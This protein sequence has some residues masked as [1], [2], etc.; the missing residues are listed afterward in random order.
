MGYLRLTDFKYGDHVTFMAQ[1]WHSFVIDIHMFFR[2]RKYIQII[3]PQM[4][5]SSGFSPS[6]RA[7]NQPERA[8]NM[9]E[10]PQFMGV[11]Q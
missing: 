6:D 11:T 8:V 3:A 1:N 4:L 2:V 10:F 9:A 5:C 7:E